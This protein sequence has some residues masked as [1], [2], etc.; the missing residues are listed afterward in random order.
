MQ[1]VLSI[2]GTR[3]EAIKMAPVVREL[4]RFPDEFSPVVCVTGQHKAMLH[5]VLDLFGILPDFDLNLM[6]PDQSL[7]ELTGKLFLNLER[8]FTEVKPDWVLA[9][10]D[11]T[12]SCVASL[13]AFYKKI[14]FG[15]VEAGLRTGDNSRP[16]PEEV[17]RKIADMVASIYFAPTERARKALLDE[18]VRGSNIHVTGN[19]VIDALQ[20]IA[21][22]P[23]D[24]RRSPIGFINDDERKIV[25]I[26]AHRRENFGQPFRNLCNALSELA[27]LFTDDVRFVYPVHL[28]P[29]VRQPVREILGG[30]ENV[31]LLEPLDYLSLIHLMKKSFIVLTDSGGIQEEAPGLGI[32]VLVMREKT[33][34]P[35]GVEAGVARLVGTDKTRIINEV[36]LLLKTRSAYEEMA[37]GV[38]PYG[39]GKA[40]VRI[41]EILRGH[42]T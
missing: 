22:K 25:L 10:G 16:F 18:G 31:H 34:R 3:P 27:K 8:V 37:K 23:F 36:S 24:W 12:T 41:V 5:Q 32:P 11:T 17:N 7:A 26:T 4:Q 30:R 1:K 2:I 40:A 14:P 29:H 19:T 21:A 38:N 6:M 9:Q 20:D 35:E 28:N 13:M 15:H 39:D 33:E 42:S